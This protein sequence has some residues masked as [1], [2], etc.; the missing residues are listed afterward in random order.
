MKFYNGRLVT[1][2]AF[3]PKGNYRIGQVINVHGKNLRIES[4]SHTGKNVVAH[5]L[6]NSGK[7]ER[8]MCLCSNSEFV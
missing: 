2:F 4:Y 1:K 6:E 7:F 8:Y 5:T 3:I